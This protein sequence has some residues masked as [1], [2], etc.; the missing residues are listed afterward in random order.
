MGSQISRTTGQNGSRRRQP[1]PEEPPARSTSSSDTDVTPEG[2]TSHRH[3]I[4]LVPPAR[5]T[6]NS[7]TEATPEEADLS[8]YEA[9]CQVDPDLRTFDSTLQVRTSRAINSIAVDLEVRS[10]SLDSLRE[11]TEC[12]LEMNQEVV[13]IIL[14]NKEDIWKNKELSDLVDDYFENSLQMLDFCTAL[15]SCLQRAGHIESIINVALRVFEEE[16]YNIP[17]EGG[18]KSYSRT[19]EELRN[20]KGAG[21]PFTE[22]F[23]KMFTTVYSQQ[24]SMLEKLKAKKKQLDKKLGRTKTWRRVSNVIFGVIFVSVL[25]CSVVAVAVIAPPVVTAL[26]AAALAMPLVSMGKWLNTIW[27]KCEKELRGQR[28]IITSMHIGSNLVIKELDSIRVLIDQL[29]I[30]IEAFLGNADFALGQDGAVVIAVVEIRKKVNDF[31]KTIQDLSKHADKCTRD[32]KMARAVILRRII[33]HI[34][35]SNQDFGMFS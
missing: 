1:P 20:L 21:R 3:N 7:N 12:L 11:V 29:Q 15:D 2:S 8:S 26:A 31:T 22:E 27:K 23:F 4:P 5:T 18:V 32:T 10:L 24:N 6:S 35:S 14:Q 33:N 19:S 17:G 13:Q 16:H 9:A 28:E 30:K 25:I 34:G